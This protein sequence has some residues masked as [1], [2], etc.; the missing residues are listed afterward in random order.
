MD[1]INRK[2][3]PNFDRDKQANTV[4]KLCMESTNRLT[5]LFYFHQG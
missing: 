3:A 2:R 4:E 5:K 1:E